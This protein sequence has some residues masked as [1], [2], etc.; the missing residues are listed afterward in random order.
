MLQAATDKLVILSP[1]RKS[2]QQEF[3]PA[4]EAHY[5]KTF[6]KEIQVDWLDQGGASDDVRFLRA[7]F[8]ADPKSS[9]IDVFWGGGTAIYID[10]ANEGFLA[11]YQVPQQ[12]RAELPTHAGSIP[13]A[14][15]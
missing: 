5:K 8:G 10:L 13:M 1:H 3:M 14:D 12:L 4:F 11:P 9:G 6:G 15:P 2:I 7:R